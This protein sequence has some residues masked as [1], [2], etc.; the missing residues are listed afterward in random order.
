VDSLK[1]RA[2]AKNLHHSPAASKSLRHY[3]L[4]PQDPG[5]MS[6][7]TWESLRS[8]LMAFQPVCGF[9][10]EEAC[11]AEKVTI[12]GGTPS[13]ITALR[14]QDSGCRVDYLAADRI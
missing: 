8:Y 14:L 2:L 10:I 4:L 11:Q 12:L 1:R 5:S 9:S 6:S 3:L 13:T 7:Q